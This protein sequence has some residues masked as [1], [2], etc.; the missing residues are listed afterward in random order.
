MENVA[1]YDGYRLILTRFVV[2]HR[3]MMMTTRSRFVALDGDHAR[4]TFLFAGSDAY[5]KRFQALLSILLTLL[6]AIPQLQYVSGQLENSRMKSTGGHHEWFDFVVLFDSLVHVPHPRSPLLARAPLPPSRAFS[7]PRRLSPTVVSPY[8]S[9]IQCAH[10]S[11]IG[12]TSMSAIK[13]REISISDGQYP[14]GSRS[15]VGAC[16]IFRLEKNN[17]PITISCDVSETNFRST[18]HRDERRYWNISNEMSK[19][20]SSDFEI[21]RMNES[22][23]PYDSIFSIESVGR[24]V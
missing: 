22:V 20:S 18:R 14:F 4:P 19:K 5:C 7:T 17:R 3:P 16:S 24:R 1:S 11:F 15:L 13:R 9:H 10:Y 23:K 6:P 2:C 21:G 12:L 8:P